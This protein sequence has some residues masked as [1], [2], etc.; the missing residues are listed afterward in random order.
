MRGR[1]STCSTR[2][3]ARHRDIL[4][5]VDRWGVQ[6]AFISSS[7]AAERLGKLS[8]RCTFLWVPEGID[9]ERYE[10]RSHL[11]RDID[12]LQIGRKY[13]VYHSAIEPALRRA[14]RT[15]LY[16]KSK[17]AL[18]FP[19]RGEFVAGLSRSRISVCVP[20]SV[21]HRE[22]AGDIETM[23]VRYLQ[24]IV[25]KCLVVGQAPTEMVELF[26]YNPV[27]EIDMASAGEQ[28]VDLLENY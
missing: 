13:D 19:T 24:S 7:Q 26:G 28:I 4:E 5:L 2:W 15:Y 18:I 20:S 3:P 12:V 11:E 14:G 10:Q 16:E 1:V 8:D 21:T 23:T 25:S 17:G 9:P 27:V 22:R 6:Y